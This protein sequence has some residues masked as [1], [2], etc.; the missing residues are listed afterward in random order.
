MPSTTQPAAVDRRTFLKGLTAV[1]GGILATACAGH[2]AGPSAS[3]AAASRASLAAWR[4]RIGLQLFTVRDR[5]MTDYPGTLRA[6]AAAG[7]R[8]VQTTLSYGGYSLDQIKQFLDQAGLVAP[9]T[10]VSPPNGP[11]FERTLDAY[12]RIG[13][14]YTT[15]NT[16]SERGPRG[17]PNA[18]PQRQTLDAVKRTAA[19]L[20]EAGRV[21]QKHGLKVIV[22]N[23]TV[24]FEPLADGSQRPYDV[25]MAETDPSLVALELDI[26]WATVAGANA[27][28]LFRRAPG[29]F[30]V[31]HVKDVAGLAS[32]AGKSEAERQRAAKIVPLGEGEIDYRAI[33]AQAGLAGMKHFFVE[34]DSAPDS[35]DSLA[36]AAASYRNLRDRV[37]A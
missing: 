37:L 15:V 5:F 11:E 35:G 7:Y 16:G 2:A 20:N 3:G 10:H 26:G 36:A 22:H 33:F 30:E 19:A 14:R 21:T 9:A 8:E 12:A 32:L 1:G 23:H 24:E 13:H 18:A 27:L 29:R 34:Q 17:V 25:L 4:D 6:V 28:E 31:W